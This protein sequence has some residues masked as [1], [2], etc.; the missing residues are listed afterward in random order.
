MVLYEKLFTRI[1]MI[2]YNKILF[3]TKKFLAIFLITIF[4]TPAF[5]VDYSEMSTQELIV[6]MGYVEK[7]N[8]SKFEKELKSRVGTMTAKEKAKYKKNLEK[9]K[10]K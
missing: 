2:K 4:I 10:S 9:T 7:K 5:A 8:K 1:L 3:I 6:I